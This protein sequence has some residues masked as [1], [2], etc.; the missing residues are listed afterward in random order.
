LAPFRR[1]PMVG[2]MSHRSVSRL[3]PPPRHV[4]LLL[5]VQLMFGGLGSQFGWV[6]FGFGTIFFWAIF[7]NCEFPTWFTF[8]GEKA[9]TQAVVIRSAET[10]CTEG[11]GED[12]SGT[13]IYAIE[14]W[15]PSVNV[16]ER[17]EGPVL[18]PAT[19]EAAAVGHRGRS[20]AVGQTLAPGTQVTI[21]YLLRDPSVSHIQGMRRAIFRAAA[22]MVG[23]F[24]FAG[25]C[26]LLPG[27]LLGLRASRLLTQGILG[28]ARLQSKKATNVEINGQ[29]VYKL[30]FQFQASDG[31][32]H[33]VV[34]KT[35]ET[36][37]VED[38]TQ[39]KIMYDPFN[40]DCAVVLDAL[41][42]SFVV[43]KVGMI[44]TAKPYGAVAVTALP[45]L[46]IVGNGLYLLLR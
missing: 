20:Y 32:M 18:L 9:T 40:A 5:R 33:S 2:S 19:A 42:G 31:L 24:P 25:L 36:R 21:E 35:H 8:W 6:F 44:Q 27:C 26:M 10:G 38:E 11:G 30:T 34:V 43:D 22:A 16:A 39:E 7:V 12:S 1:P 23:I 13:P 29:P 37:K 41:P 15:Y 28:E 45:F 46:T 14:Y 3:G 17:Q 4:P